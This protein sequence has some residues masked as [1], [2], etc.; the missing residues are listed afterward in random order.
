METSPDPLSISD[1][2]LAPYLDDFG[3]YY[4]PKY[5]FTIKESREGKEWLVGRDLSSETEDVRQFLRTESVY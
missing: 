3:K 4:D 5:L 1:R 2:L